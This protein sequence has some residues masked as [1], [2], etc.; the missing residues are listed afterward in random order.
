MKKKRLWTFNQ[1]GSWDNS[2]F[3]WGRESGR[4][5]WLWSLF[6]HLY[7]RQES[8]TNKKL[9]TMRAFNRCHDDRKCSLY[10]LFLTERMVYN[11]WFIKSGSWKLEV[12]FIPLVRRPREETK[13]C[14]MSWYCTNVGL[15]NL[16]MSSVQGF[17]ALPLLPVLG[18]VT[19]AGEV[20]VDGPAEIPGKRK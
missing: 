4:V 13:K 5:I 16:Q 6:H 8:S 7:Y 14:R 11:E 12:L 9:W 20:A 3:L 18:F 2:F 19:E 1:V 15:A 17:C 10:F